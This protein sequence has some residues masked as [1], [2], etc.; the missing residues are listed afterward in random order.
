M[1]AT[2][3]SLP[4]VGVPFG[5]YVIRTRLGRGGMGEVFLADQLGPLGPVRPVALKRLLP[6]QTDDPQVVRL[7]LEEMATAAQ[8]SHP[9]IAV[10]YDFG[11]VEG[12]YFIAMEYVD[13][14]PLDQL[15]RSSGPLPTDAVAGV[16]I[17]ITQ[18]L[19]YAHERRSAGAP[20]SVIHQDV[21]PHNIIV[22][23]E[24][25][26]K[27]LDFGIAKTEAAARQG[28][29]RAK[30]RYAAPEQLRGALPD[31]RFDIWSLGITMY[32]ALSGKLPFPQKEMADRLAAAEAGAFTP[33]QEAVP[34]AAALAPVIN[35]ALSA[36]P[37]ARFASAEAMG[38]ALLAALPMPPERQRQCL[39][40]L[41]AE[42]SCAPADMDGGELTSTGVAASGTGL[43][44]QNAS[45]ALLEPAAATKTTPLPFKD[46]APTR[47]T[48]ETAAVA[49]STLPTPK[50][51]KDRPWA[52]VIVGLLL[53]AVVVGGL[54]LSEPPSAEVHIVQPELPKVEPR[55]SS[56]S[57][58]APDAPSVEA[59]PPTPKPSSPATAKV[60]R[61]RKPLRRA[62]KKARTKAARVPQSKPAPNPVAKPKPRPATGHLSVRTVP[63]GRVFVDGRRL[64]EGVIARRPLSAGR[65]DLRLEAGEGQHSDHSV[66]IQIVGGVTTRVFYNFDT[67]ERR[68][69]PP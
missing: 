39:R 21:T 47:L 14:L 3:R 61:R 10:T 58:L 40:A 43:A 45:E 8:L 26:C 6:S 32:L 22:S 20:A 36:E 35:R 28:K 53:G 27:L 30:V 38:E 34:H 13:G 7:F 17:G 67:A 12:V 19:Q 62:P 69:T 25:E 37:D 60:V 24:G 4:P 16:A 59:I 54:R 64:G 9:N 55:V 50:Q 2:P 42:A 23:R 41:V 31:R 52:V 33:L 11:E 49:M 29:L 46:D 65:H 44:A 51:T 63:W 57:T 5:R 66:T 48:T 18:A 68:I 1:P 56:E 15:L